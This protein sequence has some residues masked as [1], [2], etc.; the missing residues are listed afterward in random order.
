MSKLLQERLALFQSK[1]LTRTLSAPSGEDL[2]SSDYLGFSIDPILKER[3]LARLQAMPTIGTGASRLLRGNLPL[4]TETESLLSAFAGRG[5]SLLFSTGYAANVGLLSAVLRKGDHVFSDALNH[6]SI[7]DGITLSKANK[8]IF[9]H[10]DYNAL[11]KALEM[12]K[13]EDHVKVIVTESIFSMEGTQ[14]DLMKLVELSKQYQALLIVDEAHAVGVYGAGLVATQHLNSDVF[15]T[16]HA[17]GKALGAAGAWVSGDAFLINYLAHFARSFIFS[18]APIPALPLLLQE[19]IRYYQEVGESRANAIRQRARMFREKLSAETLGVVDSPIVPIVIG[20]N[21]KAMVVAASLQS[22]G[23]D[24]KAIRPPTV[25]EGTARLRLTIKW[26]N[27]D[28]MLMRL[29]ADLNAIL[30]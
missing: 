3:Y 22:V 16:V 12:T 25:P 9:P 11:A 23:W 7:I 20:D 4:F 5:S 10:R 13:S 24:V 17:A 14:A 6:A 27:S 8:T 19:S 2:S 18:T 30:N 26:N 21:E 29:V 28:E 15:A 1:G